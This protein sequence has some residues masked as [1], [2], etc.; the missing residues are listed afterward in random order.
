MAE[1]KEKRKRGRPKKDGSTRHNRVGI[2]LTDDELGMLIFMCEKEGKSQTDIFMKG[3]RS[4][5]NL[6][7]FNF[8]DVEK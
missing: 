1:E 5:Y 8:E 4:Q 3:L 7:T 6:A 2:R